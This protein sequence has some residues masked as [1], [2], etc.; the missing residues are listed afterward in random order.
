MSSPVSAGIGDQLWRVY[1]PGM[2]TGDGFSHHWERNGEFSV[3]VC[4]VTRLLT[5]WPNSIKGADC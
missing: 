4:H 2:S 3:A 1:H 5:H